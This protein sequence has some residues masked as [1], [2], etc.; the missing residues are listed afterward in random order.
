MSAVFWNNNADLQYC[1]DFWGALRY[2][3]R[4]INTFAKAAQNDNFKLVL[5]IAGCAK[6]ANAAAKYKWCCEEEITQS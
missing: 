6:Y 3:D 2:S 5:V 4:T 1:A